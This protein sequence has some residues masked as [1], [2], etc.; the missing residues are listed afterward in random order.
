MKEEEL[1]TFRFIC[2]GGASYNLVANVKNIVFSYFLIITDPTGSV[3]IVPEPAPGESLPT[4]T[5]VLLTC[6]ASDFPEIPQ[7]TIKQ[8]TS[9]EHAVI[10]SAESLSIKV[11]VKLESCHNGKSFTCQAIW[12]YLDI[13]DGTLE[14]NVICERFFY[15]LFC[16]IVI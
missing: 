5:S 2:N 12:A 15:F 1:L 6:R 13:E 9:C 10:A 11:T 8:S 14:Y 3:S 4:G 7:L 16:L